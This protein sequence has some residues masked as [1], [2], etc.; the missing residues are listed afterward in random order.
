MRKHLIYI[1]LLLSCNTAVKYPPGGYD[2]PEAVADQDTSFYQLPLKNRMS[3]KDSFMMTDFASFNKE[4]DEPNLSLR[5]LPAAVFRFL[6][7]PA[8]SSPIFI[9]LK[10]DEIVTKKGRP[11]NPDISMSPDTSLL[12]P[13]ERLHLRVLER[14]FPLADTLQNFTARRRRIADSMGR[15]YPQ[16][17]SPVYYR[18]LLDKAYVGKRPY[19]TYTINRTKITPAKY[20]QLV[21][22]I[23]AS[24][25]WR[26]PRYNYC[27]ELGFD[28]YSFTLEANTAKKYN[29]VTAIQC[30]TD[31]TLPFFKACQQLVSEAHM[32]NDILIYRE[33]PSLPDTTHVIADTPLP[34]VKEEPKPRKKRR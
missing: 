22:Q 27:A 17:Y 8:L 26:L 16:L 9:I 32:D 31:S 1:V 14:Y 30:S 34:E 15:L 2:Y 33:G 7:S 24:G 11:G 10:E 3:Q 21:Q 20:R 6:Y 18:Q 25:Y 29:V 19:F 4:F 5:P 13:L 12:T 28:G 23:N